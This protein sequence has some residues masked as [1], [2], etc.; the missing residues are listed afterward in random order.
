MHRPRAFLVLVHDVDS[1]YNSLSAKAL[2]LALFALQQPPVEG[3]VRET[4][5]PSSLSPSRRGLRRG[6]DRT[7]DEGHRPASVCVCMVVPQTPQPGPAP[8]ERCLT[9]TAM[10]PG[11]LLRCRLQSRA[12]SRRER[13]TPKRWPLVVVKK[14]S[15]G[16]GSVGA[17]GREAF[18]ADPIAAKKR[19][20]VAVCARK[21]FSLRAACAAPVLASTAAK[22][23]A[24]CAWSWHSRNLLSHIILR[25]YGCGASGWQGG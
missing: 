6:R 5:A 7:A 3:V 23:R 25:S 21:V 11:Y 18:F 12:A 15:T 17:F 10:R 14:R 20:S 1:C 13:T 24:C 22:I 19:P 16:A 4:A 8:A 9:T 2:R